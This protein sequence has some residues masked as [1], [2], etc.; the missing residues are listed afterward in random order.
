MSFIRRNLNESNSKQSSFSFSS[1]WE[2]E[3]STEEE[4]KEFSQQQQN[5]RQQTNT[6]QNQDDG[7]RIDGT[8]VIF[9]LVFLIFCFIWFPSVIRRC[10]PRARER[11]RQQ[12]AAFAALQA[13]EEAALQAVMEGAAT[14][15]INVDGSSGAVLPHGMT[16]EERREF[17]SNVLLSKVSARDSFFKYGKQLF[18][19]TVFGW[20]LWRDY[21][22]LFCLFLPSVTDIYVNRNWINYHLQ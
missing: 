6:Q 18:F 21:H 20:D 13:A 10:S 15:A 11:R 2:E 3:T 19:S 1:D 16:L 9:V 7:G 14:G 17:V 22:F 12:A 8:L 4:E 5:H